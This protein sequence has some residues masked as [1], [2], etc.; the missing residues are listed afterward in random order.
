MSRSIIQ[1]ICFYYNLLT[2]NAFYSC[3]AVAIVLFGGMAFICFLY[4]PA[5]FTKHPRCAVAIVLARV[6]LFIDFNLAVLVCA[7]IKMHLF[8]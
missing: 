1:I 8:G 2:V 5:T 6:R 7:F 3:C 4:K